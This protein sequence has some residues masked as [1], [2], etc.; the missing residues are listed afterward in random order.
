MLF[1]SLNSG[2]K[3]KWLSLSEGKVWHGGL[4]LLLQHYIQ[5][6]QNSVLSQKWDLQKFVVASSC[7]KSAGG[8]KSSSH[9]SRYPAECYVA[10]F[11]KPYPQHTTNTGERT[12]LR[13]T[14][15]LFYQI[16]LT[17]HPQGRQWCK[18]DVKNVRW[19]MRCITPLLVCFST[20]VA[21]EKERLP[22]WRAVK[23]E[24]HETLPKDITKK[25]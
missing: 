16:N 3:P 11:Q 6:K 10:V 18:E 25:R 24:G 20:A 19:V 21:R 9:W 13:L 14:I 15:S 23:T 22:D 7:L 12:M 4:L 5:R 2:K 1:N 17:G 8:G